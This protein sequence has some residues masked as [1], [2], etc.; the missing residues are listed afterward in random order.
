L[1]ELSDDASDGDVGTPALVLGFVQA[2]QSRL[3]ELVVN[4]ISVGYVQGNMNSDNC[5]VG[6]HTIDFGPFGFVQKFSPTWNPF[7][8]DPEEK[9]GFLRQPRAMQLNMVTLARALITLVAAT[10]D[11]SSDGALKEH[12][13]KLQTI[14]T[15]EF[16]AELAGAM[17][18]LRV[19]KLGLADNSSVTATEALWDDLVGVVEPV[20]A[21]GDGVPGLLEVS[22]MDWTIFWRQLIEIARAGSA[23]PAT[24]AAMMLGAASYDD[25]AF[26]RRLPEWVEWVTQWRQLLPST[27]STDETVAEMS[28]AS[29]I[30]VPREWLLARAYSAAELGDHQPLHEALRVLSSP[31]TVN[32]DATVH[33]RYSRPTPPEMLTKA[34]VAYFS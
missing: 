22:Q 13:S 23:Q 5:A 12:A 7:T 29:P 6:G 33:A 15:T 1:A 32:G 26:E 24:A 3:I 27:A 14:V 30:Y 16:E 28:R 2:V 31:F 9:F 18:S 19:R 17:H 25:V 10:T 11:S 8:S 34:G 21:G 20:E 4:W